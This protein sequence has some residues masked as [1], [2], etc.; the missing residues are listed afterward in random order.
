MLQT[1]VTSTRIPS[2]ARGHFISL[3]SV[4]ALLTA[5][6]A[7]PPCA[8]AQPADP[9]TLASFRQDPMSF[10]FDL[11]QTEAIACGQVVLADASVAAGERRR[12]LSALAAV[13]LA[14]GRAPQ[15]RAAI[16]EILRDDPGAELERPEVLPPPLVTLFY[17]LRDS[18]LLAG[19][20][21]GI[22]TSRLDIRTLA[23]GDIENNSIVTGKY[24]LNAFAKGLTQIMITDL[25]EATPLTLVDRQRLNVLREEIQMSQNA[26]IT[27]PR[28][29]VP[30]GKLTGAQSFLFGSLMQVDEK[31]VRLDLRWVDTSTGEIL[32]AEGVEGSLGSSDDLF[33]LERRVLLEHLVPRL[34]KLLGSAGGKEDLEKSMKPYLE[35]KRKALLKD[36]AY[37]DLLLKTGEA[38]LAEDRGDLAAARTAWAEVSRIN[39][40]D[41][42]ATGRAQGLSAYLAMNS[43]GGR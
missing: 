18:L 34:Q 36:T 7:M 1:I 19:G 13:H 43:G 40:G 15:A 8:S 10:F 21:D 27:D 9:T 25:Q 3:L 39:P 32:L 4:L 22:G 41:E 5:A 33:K 31:K 23:V 29:R 30:L 17:G 11:R 35:D 16:L 38:I 12:V 6:A 14:S 37:M 2:A 24:N 26:Q 42:A 20:A 28:Y